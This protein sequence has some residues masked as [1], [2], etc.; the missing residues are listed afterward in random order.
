MK[1]YFIIFIALLILSSSSCKEKEENSNKIQNPPFSG[2]IF[3]DPDIITSADE[4]IFLSASYTGHNIR[5]MF[6]RRVND[7]ITVEAYLFEA[8]FDDGSTC[9]IQ[10]NPE[11]GSSDNAF[12]E[13]KKI[14]IEVGRL[15][16]ALRLDVE[17]I[18][19]HKGIQPFG[20]GNNNILIHTGQ[21]ENYIRGGILEETLVHEA[22]HTSF[23][24]NHGSSPGWLS[25]QIED[26]VFIS[27][28]AEEHP[29]RE[30]IAESFLPYLAIRYRSNRI[31]QSTYNTIV[32]TIPNR[33]KYFDDQLFNVHPMD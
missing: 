15:P 29:N 22:A 20:G 25:A 27:T 9:E 23:D 26:G 6:D 2:T 32:Q 16:K 4:T 31:S 28:Y 8:T 10:V 17:T 12:V 1:N 21:A 30:D 7:W 33:I 3:I 24:K 19:I 11:F 5:T 13:A 18:W 14:G